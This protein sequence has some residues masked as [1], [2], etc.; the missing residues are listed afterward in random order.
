MQLHA[1]IFALFEVYSSWLKLRESRRA[2]GIGAEILPSD[3]KSGLSKRNEW[4]HLFWGEIK[5]QLC[6]IAQ[7][8]IGL[9]HREMVG[10]EEIKFNTKEENK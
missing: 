8:T 3:E 1:I 7:W 4:H 5:K 9:Q 10:A 6:V 2:V